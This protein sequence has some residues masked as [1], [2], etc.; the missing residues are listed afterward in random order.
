MNRIK[1]LRKNLNI[2]QKKL[3]KQLSI[4]NSTL[5]QYEDGKRAVPDDIKIRLSKIFSVSL[6]FLM[7]LNEKNL[8]G[9]KIPILGTIPA[10]VPIEAVQN[11]L[12]YEEITPQL[13]LTGEF[14]ALRVKGDSMSPEILENDI[15]IVKQQADV[16]SGKVAIL[17][18]N[19]DNE[20]TVKR[21]RKTTEGIYLM[22]KNDKYNT[23]FYS[24]AEIESLPVTIIGQVVENRRPY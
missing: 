4:A 24:N 20:A 18:V 1:Q 5:S 6:D 10:G 3:A 9:I 16:E 15:L 8:T 11:I 7:G 22:P 21:I 14:F 17:F 13:A 19:G 2:T 23:V 12:G